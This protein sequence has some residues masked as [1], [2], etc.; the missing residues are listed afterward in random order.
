MTE[1]SILPGQMTIEE[2][3]AAVEAE[4]ANPRTPRKAHAAG[5][6][7]RAIRRGWARRTL[8]AQAADVEGLQ[9]HGP[10]RRAGRLIAPRSI[11]AGRLWAMERLRATYAATTRLPVHGPLHVWPAERQDCRQRAQRPAEREEPDAWGRVCA[12]IDAEELEEARRDFR[13][14][15][16]LKS[17]TAS[18]EAWVLLER[19]HWAI[20]NIG[21]RSCSTSVA[22]YLPAN[23]TRVDRERRG[24]APS[25]PDQLEFIA[26]FEAGIETAFEEFEVAGIFR[27]PD[28]Q[29]VLNIRAVEARAALDKRCQGMQ[30]S[31]KK[32]RQ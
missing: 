2:G 19:R 7:T 16:P 8:G 27:L 21:A 3:I 31:T 1:L 6:V 26:G 30:E 28:S 14:Q 25:R 4:Q 29:W 22:C 13:D 5:E 32:S 18:Y 12:V 24:T 15:R 23:L 10:A 9:E 20:T 11:S 17:A